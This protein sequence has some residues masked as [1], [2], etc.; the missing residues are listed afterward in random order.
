MAIPL[1]DP[2]RTGL[3]ALAG[4]AVERVATGIATLVFG[5]V[6]V[7][8]MVA[9]VL[10]ALTAE[11]GFPLAALIVASVFAALALAVYLL[12]RKLSARRAEQRAVARRQARADIVLAA[13]LSR[14]A[15]PLLPVAAFLAAFALM[16][17]R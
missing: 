1:L 8:L 6:A 16:Q 13:A 3:S 11:V 17:R 5:G 9:A 7:A 4:D 14:S 2:L 15:R 10:V 12:G